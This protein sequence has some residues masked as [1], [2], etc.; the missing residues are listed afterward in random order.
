MHHADG[1]ISFQGGLAY[2]SNAVP[3]A[4]VEV[5]CSPHLL[6]ASG[7]DGNGV[8]D[9]CDVAAATSR[10]GDGVPDECRLLLHVPGQ[11]ATIQATTRSAPSAASCARPASPRV[12]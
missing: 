1:V 12:G 7:C 9:P 10:D 5:P 11:F 4:I 8:P 2:A 6:G 3:R